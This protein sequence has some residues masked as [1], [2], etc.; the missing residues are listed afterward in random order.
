MGPLPHHSPYR[1]ASLRCFALAMCLGVSQAY[2]LTGAT[3]SLSTARIA[4]SSQASSIVM[5]AK[6]PAAK[7]SYAL[8]QREKVGGGAESIG[9]LVGDLGSQLTELDGAPKNLYLWIGGRGL[10]VLKL[11]GVF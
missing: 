3:T 2:C 5:M 7:K 6:K 10:L 4:S 1:M 11:F 9:A 8:K